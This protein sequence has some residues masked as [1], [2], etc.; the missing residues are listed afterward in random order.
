MK[1]LVI[2]DAGHA[3]K[4]K[5]KQAPDKS[6]R[7]WDFNN[8]MQYKLKKRFED[9]GIDVY[10][11]NPK[12]ENIDEIG[13]T[14]RCE[15]ANNY[16]KKEGKPK[17][18]FISIHANAHLSEFT[19]ARGTETYVASNASANSKIAAKDVQE[20]IVKEMRSIDSKAIDRG[21]KVADFTVI[22]KVDMPSIL[23]E[24]AFYTNREDLKILKNNKDELA[25]ATV[26]GV[27]KYFGI[28]YKE[29]TLRPSVTEP[30]VTEDIFYRVVAGSYL[31]RNNADKVSEKLKDSKIDNFIIPFE[32][33]G[34]TYFRVIAGSYND[35]DRSE[36]QL[37]KIKSMGY[38]AFIDVYK[39]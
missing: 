21:V 12:P 29:S 37:N 28:D 8:Q 36:E 7:E 23:I 39:K 33:D 10:L 30:P 9:Y 1:Y 22:Y 13:L 20:E 6:L 31:D 15:L 18:L 24:Y 27:C 14:R 4:V 34:K 5:G 19:S 3:E 25:E 32:K 17:S 38:D 26:K 35:R 2:L 11:T 16:W